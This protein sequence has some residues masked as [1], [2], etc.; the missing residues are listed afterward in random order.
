MRNTRL[1]LFSFALLLSTYVCLAQEAKSDAKTIAA[2]KELFENNCKACHRVKEKLVGPALA[3][4]EDRA[5]SIEWIKSWVRNS[6]K[7]I[8]SG[9]KYAVKIFEE[10]NKAPMTSFAFKDEEIMSILAYVNDEAS[11]KVE[12]A[13]APAGADGKPAEGGE[14]GIPAKYLTF[15]LIAIGLVL[16]VVIVLL[17]LV[18]NE[19]R[20]YLIRQSVIEEDEEDKEEEAAHTGSFLRSPIF[21]FIVGFL[22]V[23]IGFKMTI[24]GLY[25]IGVQKDYQ[26]TQPIAFSHKIHAGQF[27]IDCKYCHTGTLKGKQANIPSANICMNC[28]KSIT[29]GTHTGTAEIS[30]I[31]KAVGYDPATAK[32]TGNQQPIEWVRIHNLPD[33]AYFNHSQHVK[34][35]G[36]ECQTCHGQVQ[37]MDVVKQH[38]NLTMGWCI[39]CHRKTDLNTEGNAYYTKLEELHKTAKNN[40]T[41]MKVEDIGG[42]ECSKCHY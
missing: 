16:L 7:M 8:A 33:L 31:Y 35:A 19:L 3:G 10:S 1:L 37:E 32:Y 17:T 42:L 6:A 22:V 38:A 15:I 29:S 25:T 40:R 34:V 11:K 39:D 12:V 2:G 18:L 14:S 13:A 28:H 24:D 20:K 23:S 5:P 36:V 30:K 27:Q 9:D 21:H 4:V 26:P 41:K